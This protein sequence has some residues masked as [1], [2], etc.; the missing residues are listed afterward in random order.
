MANVCEKVFQESA[1]RALLPTGL[2]LSERLIA[3]QRLGPAAPVLR[4]LLSLS[5]K[6]EGLVLCN[7]DV[8]LARICGQLSG[9]A[10]PYWVA[11]A[12]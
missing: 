10:V 12:G 3:P 8:Y 4:H 2:P 6:L 9:A 1:A 7:R 5:V 11:L